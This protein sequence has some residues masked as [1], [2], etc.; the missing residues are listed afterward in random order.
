ME[1]IINKIDKIVSSANN[2]DDKNT[3]C[4]LVLMSISDIVRECSTANAWLSS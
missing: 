1:E 4:I 3:G 2:D